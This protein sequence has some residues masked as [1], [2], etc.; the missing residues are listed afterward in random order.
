[1]AEIDIL[2][3]P[4]LWYEN[5]PLV[6]YEAFASNTPVIATALGGMAEAVTHEVNGLLFDRG[7]VPELAN[8]LQRVVAEPGLVERL[9]SGIRPVRTIG[10]EVCDLEALYLSLIPPER[11]TSLANVN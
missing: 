6:I 8:M 9:R 5:A 3:V 7:N 1:M 2:V 11:E 10:D 4:S